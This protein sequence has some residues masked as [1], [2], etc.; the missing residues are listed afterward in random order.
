M[1]AFQKL[2]S[3]H[4]STL[5]VLGDSTGVGIGA[6]KPEDSVPG[7]LAQLMNATYVENRAVS[8]A[9]AADIKSQWSGAQLTH[10]DVILFQVG[11]NDIVKLHRPRKT[12]HT[13]LPLL[14]EAA[15]R[16]ERVIFITAGNVGAASAIPFFM[17]TPYRLLSLRYYREFAKIAAQAGVTFINLYQPPQIDPFVAHPSKY[18]AADGFHPSSE[19]Y[20]LWFEQIEKTL[21]AQ[22]ETK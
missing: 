14:E 3:D 17:R 12:A 11:A 8:G 13:L 15:S 18:L 20:K 6:L 2:G 10:Y 21:R 19:G 9:V 7:R 16:S 22:H 5:L 4:R 1:A